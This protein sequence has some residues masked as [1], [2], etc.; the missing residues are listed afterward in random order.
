MVEPEVGSTVFRINSNNQGNF[1]VHILRFTK[2]K[3][4]LHG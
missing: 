4:L 1:S 2:T 3:G